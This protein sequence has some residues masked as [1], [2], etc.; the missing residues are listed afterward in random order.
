MV[1]GLWRMGYGRRDPHLAGTVASGA[2][3]RPPGRPRLR[4]AGCIPPGLALGSSQG[5]F[6]VLVAQHCKPIFF[7][8]GDASPS[9]FGTR[10]P[11]LAHLFCA[12]SFQRV[13]LGSRHAVHASEVSLA[14][15][16]PMHIMLTPGFR[17]LYGTLTGSPPSSLSRRSSYSSLF[18]RRRGHSGPCGA[19]KP[20]SAQGERAR[21]HG[22]P[23]RGSRA[24]PSLEGY[25]ACDPCEWE[26]ST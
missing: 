24:R 7:P 26:A 5:V 18:C 9:V 3:R 25:A 14:A 19:P 4:P 1:H 8:R 17:I 6:P 10:R 15:I 21:R 16:P 13:H 11:S 20:S 23:S 2:P 12:P 22:P